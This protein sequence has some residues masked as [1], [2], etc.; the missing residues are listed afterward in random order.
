[1]ALWDKSGKAGSGLSGVFRARSSRRPPPLMARRTDSTVTAPCAPSPVPSLQTGDGM[2]APDVL[3]APGGKLVLSDAQRAHCVVLQDGT[4]FV[5]ANHLGDWEL[6]NAV[7]RAADAA[8]VTLKPAQPVDFQTIR[9][10]YK[11]SDASAPA[12]GKMRSQV[13]TLLERAAQSRVSDIQV[14]PDADA[15]SVQFQVNGYLT[16]PNRRDEVH[17]ND[18]HNLHMAVFNM[19]Q[20][21]DPI[22]NRHLDQKV[23]ITDR[24]L[25]PA[26]VAGARVQ[27]VPAGA[28]RHMNI[29]LLYEKLP[30]ADPSI[31]AL[32]LPEEIESYL[33][34]LLTH[35]NGLLTICG[36]TESG[37]SFTQTCWM[38]SLLQ[39][40]G[41]TLLVVSLA[42]PPE[43]YYPG[44]IPYAIN[45]EEDQTGAAVVDRLTRA[46][47]RVSP[48]YVNFAEIRTE[49]M[50]RE[51]YKASTQGK[52]ILATLHT[53]DC[54]GVPNRYLK[55]GVDFSDAFAHTS[56][57]AM[58]AQ[59]LVP[60]LCPKCSLSAVEVAKGSRE[61]AAELS[62]YRKAV[63]ALA[64]TLKVR[65]P[66]CSHCMHADRITIPGLMARQLYAELARPDAKLFA[67]LRND[68]QGSEDG[69]P[70]ARQYWFN[71]LNGKSMRL[72]ALPDLIA[73]NIGM[74]EFTYF[75]GDPFALR[76]DVTLH[77]DF[78][79]YLEKRAA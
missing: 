27:W 24:N 22:P 6:L 9:N 4:L 74:A 68:R 62:V 11:G 56:H 14:I 16:A 33:Y 12:V 31:A 54:L 71:E 73:G 53:E 60:H 48:H 63:G 38:L 29:R 59:R 20:H 2:A 75:F 41:R 67:R 18:L 1:M 39:R 78:Q 46:T 17:L 77:P 19:A 47:L 42:D 10:H 61:I 50:A 32:G 40:H 65:G 58:M 7:R 13:D 23:T 55:L 69:T 52:F 25:L 44:I 79:G 21:G 57:A 35:S 28:H 76:D 43:G 26:N 64:D 49:M 34:F 8:K 70:L 72:Y 45:T 3:S 30:A 51:A 15:A 36:P 37:K 66:G 5:H